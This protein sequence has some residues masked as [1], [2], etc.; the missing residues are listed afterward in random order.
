MDQF[1]LQ[2]NFN[3]E[4]LEQWALAARQKEDDNITLEKYKRADDAKIKELNLATER[5]TIEVGRKQSELEKE[6]TETQATQIEL[7]KTAEEFKIHHE[8][9]HKHFIQW[10][11]VSEN[12]ARRD[13][14]IIEEGE[15]FA[16]IKMKIKE[17]QRELEK[18]KKYLAEE[19]AQNKN[20]EIQ[21]GANERKIV[22]ERSQNK[23]LEEELTNLEAEVEILKNQLSAFASELSQKKNKLKILF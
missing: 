9:R 10:Q 5:L 19:K 7:D 22:D 17:N 8:E 11:E 20:L 13:Q 6:V 18:R 1:K 4:Q 16:A 2:M 14:A 3:Q 12:I 23:R 21:I 15:N